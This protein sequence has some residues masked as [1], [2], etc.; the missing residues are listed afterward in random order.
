MAG[1]AWITIVFEGVVHTEG[2]EVHD[3]DVSGARGMRD[4]D[5]RS[6]CFD[7]QGNAWSTRGIFTDLQ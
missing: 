3:E 2:A 1:G 4:Q 7:V 5:D 6:T